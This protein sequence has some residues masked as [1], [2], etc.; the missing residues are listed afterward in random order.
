MVVNN[1][2]PHT[3]N[4][5]NIQRKQLSIYFCNHEC[6]QFYVTNLMLKCN[7]NTKFYLLVTNG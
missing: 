3:Y 7:C 2:K 4:N 5:N 1:N 6:F